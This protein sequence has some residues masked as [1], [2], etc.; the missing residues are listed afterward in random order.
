MTYQ[1]TVRAAQNID[2]LLS[3]TLDKYYKS[4]LM[5]DAIFTSNPTFD[6]LKSAG[7]IKY[8]DGGMQLAI[9]LMYGKNSTVG[10]YSRY[11]ELN[12]DPQDG[13]TQAFFPWVQY[14]GAITIDGLSEFQNS[15]KAALVNL[16]GEKM[17][18]LTMSFSEEMNEDLFDSTVT[19]D[20]SQVSSK[21]L[22]SINALIDN[23]NT[24][25]QIDSS[26]RE[27]WQ[28]SINA[29]GADITTNQGLKEAM[30]TKYN[31]VSIGSGGKAT[32]LLTTQEIF[33]KYENSMQEQI[34][35]TSTETATAGFEKLRYKAATMMWDSDCTTGS[36]YFINP[37]FLKLMVAR[38][39][40][41]RPGGFQRGIK[42]DA[43]TANYLWYGQLVSS[44][45]RK[46]GAITGIDAS[47]INP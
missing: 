14:A 44:N 27:W 40:D 38:G 26:S 15:G 42:Q 22:M 47:T 20:A 28:S 18:Q 23:D 19:G 1:P 13:I 31:D 32:L 33:E 34:R 6:F 9:N 5:H 11:E 46:L 37:K 39:R 12:I 36:M 3:T 2:A 21:Q 25:G 24:V 45:R 16:L 17:E 4:G 10:P 41:F 30:G 8:I 29:S 35:Y 43:R 7:R